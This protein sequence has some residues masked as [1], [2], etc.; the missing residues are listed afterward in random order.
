[1]DADT[2]DLAFVDL[3]LTDADGVIRA[4]LERTVSVT[5]D[6]P[7]VLQALGSANPVTEEGFTNGEHLTFGGRALAVVRPSG[8]GTITVTARCEDCEP[9]TVMLTA[10]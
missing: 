3:E 8:P 5:V 9:V 7:G 2:R 10:R 1:M 6:G 4:D